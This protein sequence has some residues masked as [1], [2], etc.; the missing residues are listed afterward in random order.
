ME[1]YLKLILADEDVSA[2][3]NPSIDSNLSGFAGALITIV[4]II[5][6]AA[7]VIIVMVKGTQ[8]FTAAPDGKAQLKEDIPHVLIAAV[9]LFSVGSIIKI[10]GNFA[11]NNIK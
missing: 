11:I 6:Y 10:V 4:Q 1:K 9:I 7:A 3:L 5:C 8:Y 2:V